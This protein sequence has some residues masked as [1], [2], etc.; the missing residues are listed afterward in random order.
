MSKW[1]EIEKSYSHC[2]PSFSKKRKCL[3]TSPWEELETILLEW[4]KQAHATKASIDGTHL[5]EKALHVVT[6]LGIDGFQA[7]NGWINHFQKRHNL[8]Y[9]DY[10]ERKCHCK[11]RNSD[12]LEM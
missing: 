1:S 6:H 10:T 3:K 2:G 12:G 9:K 8:L 4:F 11:S 7:S 5:K